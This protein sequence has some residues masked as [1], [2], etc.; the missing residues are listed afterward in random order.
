MTL[1][2]YFYHRRAFSPLAACAALLFICSA[3]AEAQDD[4]ASTNRKAQITVKFADIHGQVYIASEKK[5]SRELP[6][7]GV[8]IQVRDVQSNAVQQSTTTDEQGKY[9]LT[10]PAPGRYTLQIGAMSLSLEVTQESPDIRELPKIIIAIL[11]KDLAREK[12]ARRP[13]KRFWGG[14]R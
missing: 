1:R 12:G 8:Y 4:S 10:R 6:A 14:D 7:Q 13:E 11:P 9:T 5:G 3:G 2:K